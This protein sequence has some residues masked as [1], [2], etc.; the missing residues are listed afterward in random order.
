[1]HYSSLLEMAPKRRMKKYNQ[2]SSLDD[3]PAPT[4]NSPWTP[5]VVQVEGQNFFNPYLIFHG[6]KVRNVPVEAMTPYDIRGYTGA[7][8]AFTP[9]N[10]KVWNHFE[11]LDAPSK[12]LAGEPPNLRWESNRTFRFQR[13]L[14]DSTSQ[15]DLYQLLGYAYGIDE[16]AVN[17]QDIGGMYRKACKKF[18]PDKVI[19]KF[20]ALGQRP[21][22]GIVEYATQR[23]HWIQTAK[24]ILSDPYS[25]AWWDARNIRVREFRHN[26]DA[27]ENK[28]GYK[29]PRRKTGLPEPSVQEPA[30]AAPVL[31][32]CNSSE[33]SE[34]TSAE[35]PVPDAPPASAAS[36]SAPSRATSA[37]SASEG[38]QRTTPGKRIVAEFFKKTS[39]EETVE[40]DSA[41]SPPEEDQVPPPLGLRS[42][43]FYQ[44][45]A[46]ATVR[47][48][49]GPPP[50]DVADPKDAARS[51][52]NK[53]SD[54]YR[55]D[56]SVGDSFNGGPPIPPWLQ[57][58]IAEELSDSRPE[59]NLAI[60]NAAGT[61]AG[62]AQAMP[63]P[64]VPPAKLKRRAESPSD[65]ST[66][67][68]IPKAKALVQTAKSRPTSPPTPAASGAG[69]D[70]APTSASE[71]LGSFVETVSSDS[72]SKRL[73]L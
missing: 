42:L 64:P 32:P 62:I 53:M 28:P 44:V 68:K 71:Q 1:M 21:P 38:R 30:S 56:E 18:H 4:L 24:D 29:G 57:N 47:P 59:A 10:A 25:K 23:L 50:S 46:P 26:F 61:Q 6:M 54:P 13:D 20:E 36:S 66:S 45:P 14:V 8:R 3:V 7:T 48:P 22:P 41:D 40:S 70:S 51:R 27:E 60:E 19:S 11:Y 63:P 58:R 43:S 55:S 17:P 39:T 37:S 31:I 35:F 16:A 2:Q 52:S 34:A 67:A 49:P 69:S 5:A 65:E 73:L 72:R 9:F 33:A 15:E 12:I